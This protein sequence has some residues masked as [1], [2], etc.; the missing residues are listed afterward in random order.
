LEHRDDSVEA[1]DAKLETMSKQ[2]IESAARL[3]RERKSSAQVFKTEVQRELKDL[4]FLRCQFDIQ[5]KSKGESVEE[6]ESTGGDS[7]EFQ[8]SS[9]RGE[10]MKSLKSIASSGELAR[11]MLALKTVLAAQDRIPVLLFDEV[12]AN[13]GGETAKK[14]GE[15]M[16]NLGKFHQ[17]FCVTHL[18]PVAAFSSEHFLVTKETKS[19]RTLSKVFKLVPEKRVQ[20]LARMLGGKSEGALQHARE[21]LVSMPT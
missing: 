10:P 6:L 15:K 3:S 7:L 4:G 18:A 16:R 5:F 17:V 12:D 9:N 13:I 19:N 2:L 8:F 21:L 20:E 14:V 1:L 11:V